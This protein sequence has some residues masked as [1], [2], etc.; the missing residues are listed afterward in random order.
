MGTPKTGCSA[1]GQTKDPG[2]LRT[3]FT[4]KSVSKSYGRVY[5]L[6]L[7]VLMLD[8][9]IFSYPRSSDFRGDF[10]ADVTLPWG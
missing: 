9:N 3:D 1:G 10:N 8:L 4:V 2:Q 6:P 7:H 5:V